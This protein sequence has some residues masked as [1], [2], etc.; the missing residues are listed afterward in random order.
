MYELTYLGNGATCNGTMSLTTTTFMCLQSIGILEKSK[1]KVSSLERV[2]GKGFG[3]CNA[4]K[5][6]PNNHLHNAKKNCQGHYSKPH[7][8]DSYE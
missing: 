6:N 8:G 7:V 3:A 5:A 4:K 1:E 2:Q